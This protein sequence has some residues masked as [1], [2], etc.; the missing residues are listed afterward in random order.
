MNEELNPGIRRTVEWLN[1]LG[2]ETSDSGD[3]KTNVEIGMEEAL[4]FSHVIIIVTPEKLVEE[5]R[6]LRDVLQSKGIRIDAIAMDMELPS[7]QASFDPVDEIG[8]I[9]LSGVDDQKLFTS[10]IVLN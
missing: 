6:R 9:F 8:I 5:T 10:K 2:F 4:P 3:G 7:I 1:S